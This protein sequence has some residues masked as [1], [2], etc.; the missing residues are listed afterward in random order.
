MVEH[1]A[2][3]GTELEPS[4][5]RHQRFRVEHVSDDVEALEGCLCADC[6]VELEGWLTAG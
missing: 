1:C 4:Q 2:N 6:F 5:A 3:C